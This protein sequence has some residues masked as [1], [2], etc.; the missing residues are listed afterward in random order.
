MISGVAASMPRKRRASSSVFF[1]VMPL[2]SARRLDAWIAGPSA[3]GSLNGMP[4]SIRS[5]PAAG[6]P[7]RISHD[8]SRSGSPAVTKVTNPPRPSFFSFA[9]RSAMRPESAAGDG[10]VAAAVAALMIP[11]SPLRAQPLG[12]GKDILVASAAHVHDQ[13]VILRQLAGDAGHMGQRMGRFQ[14]GDDALDARAE[15]ERRQRLVIRGRYILHAFQVME[16]GALRPDARIVQ[17]RGNRMGIVD[18]PVLVLQQ[19]GAVAMEHAGLA[20]VQ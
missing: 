18:L 1:S 10:L 5:A 13:E 7:L 19:I 2:L 14:R 12:N 17:A 9:K 3:I 6:R 8:V 4:S 20:A 16:P 15:L 11:S